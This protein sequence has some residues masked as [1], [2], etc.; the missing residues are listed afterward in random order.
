MVDVV[1]YGPPVCPAIE[2][3]LAPT[4]TLVG[5]AGAVNLNLLSGLLV[6]LFAVIEAGP[7]NVI[8]PGSVI[9]IMRLSQPARVVQ[10]SYMAAE[11]VPPAS[12]GP[13]VVRAPAVSTVMVPATVPS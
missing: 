11:T 8:V 10:T 6:K 5:T 2:F 13:V 12:T 9:L 7:V 3:R 1:V 4:V